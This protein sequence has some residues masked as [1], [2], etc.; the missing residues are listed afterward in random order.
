M[1]KVVVP[2][3]RIWRTCIFPQQ[4]NPFKLQFTLKGIIRSYNA[5]YPVMVIADFEATRL[6]GRFV[7]DVD[8][9]DE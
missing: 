4:L 8:D 1:D 2:S 5:I 9:D 3:R 7:R 6:P